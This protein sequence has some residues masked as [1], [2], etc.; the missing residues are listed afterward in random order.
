MAEK[1]LKNDLV[2]EAREHV[3]NG[4]PVC[5]ICERMLCSLCDEVEQ[6][7]RDRTFLGDRLEAQAETM[8][9]I[10]TERNQLR[11]VRDAQA[12]SITTLAF[13]PRVMEAAIQTALNLMDRA[14]YSLD[15]YALTPAL[16]M[17]AGHLRSAITAKGSE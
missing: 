17:A 8:S 12:E 16:R 10:V 11:Q 2:A 5:G 1:E 6:L 7:R 14:D 13:K 3:V 15:V 4:I 9:R